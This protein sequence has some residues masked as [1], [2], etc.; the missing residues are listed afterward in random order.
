MSLTSTITSKA[1]GALVGKA[2]SALSSAVSGDQPRPA[3]RIILAGNDISSAFNNRLESLTLT[4]NRGFEADTLDITLDDSDGR[5]AIPPRGVTLA[6]WLGWA[7]APLID[8]GTYIVDE[9][10]HSGA[11][12]K[13]TI[14]ARSTDLRTGLTE[15]KER[16][17]NGKTIGDIVQSIAAQYE[18][19]PMVSDRLK[20]EVIE[21]MDQ[22]SESDVNLLTRLAE[23]FD[24]IATVK[25]G[26]LLFMN[27]GEAQSATGISFP[28]CKLLR[29][30]GD[31]HRFSLA[32]R[33]MYTSVR[34]FYQDIK[35][36]LKGEVTW[37]GKAFEAAAEADGDTKQKRYTSV[38]TFVASAKQ[39]KR[40]IEIVTNDSGSK[41][42]T[43]LGNIHTLTAEKK[44]TSTQKVLA[45]VYAKQAGAIK[46]GK[47]EWKTLKEKQE[48][49]DT[50]RNSQITG[51]VDPMRPS[52]DSVK[53]LRHTYANKL[54]A[55]RAA[56]A[57]W[58]R[59][60]RSGATLSITAAMAHPEL[61][62]EL[63]VV[64]QGFKP[65]I[66]GANWIITRCTH[67]LS[68]SGFTTA[69]E[70]EL[71]ANANT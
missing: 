18:L 21:H 49:A 4:D 3:Y 33:D 56:R 44:S 25:K 64:V 30:S 38:K 22:T 69:F 63:P 31:Q 36:A 54:N 23:D 58:L 65:E 8:K 13:L 53:V 2:L 9:I 42:T 26:M 6:L 37:D 19:T 7:G 41:A 51:D 34:A 59:L 52:A 29:S 39:T 5:L 50:A 46:A 11:P 71:K 55:E 27:I 15:R 45:T 70:F 35:Q 28:T 68:D 67:S 1:A 66:D 16:S 62:P 32:E 47:A 40:Y 43:R 17:W 12:D 61:F 10:E 57:E 14:R 24:A 48:K 20:N 60:Q